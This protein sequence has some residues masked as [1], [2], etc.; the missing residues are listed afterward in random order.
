MSQPVAGERGALRR[1]LSG[2]RRG[3]RD[4]MPAVGLA[5]AVLVVWEAVIR[6]FAV[7]AFVLP[8]PT[9]IIASLV[10][11]R[12]SLAV[13]APVYYSSRAPPSLL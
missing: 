8:A 10:E 4:I 11:N 5:V 1:G 6:L 12:S 9:A 3:S 2:A 13:A 7:P